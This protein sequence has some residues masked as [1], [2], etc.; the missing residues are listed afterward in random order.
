MAQIPGRGTSDSSSFQVVSSGSG[1]PLGVSR[2]D[3]L[4]L[5]LS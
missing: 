4:L 5:N 2:G 1:F 3:I